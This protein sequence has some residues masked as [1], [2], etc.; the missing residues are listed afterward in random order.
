MRKLLRA[1]ANIAFAALMFGFVAAAFAG[2][3]V[4][5]SED[6]TQRVE[7]YAEACTSDNVNAR[8][9]A[10]REAFAKML[11]GFQPEPKNATYQS[12]KDSP[13]KEVGCWFLHPSA[14]MVV[15]VWEKGGTGVVPMFLFDA[16]AK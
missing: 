2:E 16:P 6:E 12:P 11:D 4:A 3:M 9:D 10:E 1:L 5:Q 14:P 7:L 13:V 15:M 8:I